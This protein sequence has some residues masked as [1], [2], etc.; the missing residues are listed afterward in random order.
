[1]RYL[2]H[3]PFVQNIEPLDCFRLTTS[4][5]SITS[6]I[7]GGSSMRKQLSQQHPESP[8]LQGLEAGLVISGEVQ[9]R[10]RRPKVAQE[11][12]PVPLSPH[13]VMPVHVA[14]HYAF[15]VQLDESVRYAGGYGDDLR[16]GIVQTL[17]VYV[18]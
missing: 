8:N 4:I 13:D 14:V 16:K 1:M 15:F 7:F 6:S 9:S 10:G 3:T 11:C 2:S 12:M 5:Y 18:A 17:P